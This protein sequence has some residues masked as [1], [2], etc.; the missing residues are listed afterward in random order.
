VAYV[1]ADSDNRLLAVVAGVR[2]FQPLRLSFHCMSCS[3]TPSTISELSMANG[4][5][6]PGASDIVQ[7]Q[8]SRLVQELWAKVGDGMKG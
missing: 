3:Q 1:P 7:E 5:L 6:P 8:V 2:F 4:F